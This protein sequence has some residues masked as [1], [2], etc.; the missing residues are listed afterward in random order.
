Q[1]SRIVS[2]GRA[3]G[4]YRMTYYPGV[5]TEA[6]AKVIELSESSEVTDIDIKLDKPMR[7]YE[8]RGR[9]VDGTTGAPLA[10]LRCGYGQLLQGE[11][12]VSQTSEET[13][14]NGEFVLRSL[15][16]GQH[17]VFLTAEVL[18]EYY[19]DQLTFEVTNQNVEG[20]E[21]KA[22]RG[23]SISGQLVL[24]GTNDP[25]HRQLLRRVVF[26]ARSEGPA[27]W[28]GIRSAQVNADGTFRITGLRPGKTRLNTFIGDDVPLVLVRIERDGVLLGEDLNLTA[29]EQ[30]SGVKVVFAYGTG[31]L[32]GQLNI[33]GGTLPPDMRLAIEVQAQGRSAGRSASVDDRGRF[34]IE[35]LAAGE[36]A[37]SLLQIMTTGIAG[38]ALPPVLLQTITVG[39]GENNVTLTFDLKKEGRQ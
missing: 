5:S 6:D 4:L 3:G 7:M 18:P 8:A 19:S 1:D 16:P 28:R 9:V 35:G 14:A 10:G 23:A 31:I 2:I 39:R 29:A 12:R 33:A 22:Y 26:N 17:G 15:S 13:N 38:R 36:Y 20:L 27:P 21:I 11:M 32:R 25:A 34:V 24:E 30:V 37:L